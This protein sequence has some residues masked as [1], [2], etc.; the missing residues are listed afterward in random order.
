VQFIP[1]AIIDSGSAADAIDAICTNRFTWCQPFGAF[2]VVF[3]CEILAHPQIPLSRAVPIVHGLPF[4]GTAK[5][6]LPPLIARSG[7]RAVKLTHQNGQYV[8]L[9]GWHRLDSFRVFIS[10]RFGIVRRLSSLFRG[11]DHFSRALILVLGIA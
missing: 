4:G 8:V 5:I 2:L 9:F 6:N 7:K 10:E 3:S 11:P 1:L